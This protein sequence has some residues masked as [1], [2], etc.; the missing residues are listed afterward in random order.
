M[1]LLAWDSPQ[2]L[3][4]LL[5]HKRVNVRKVGS[6]PVVGFVDAGAAEALASARVRA[7]FTAI[8]PRRSWALSGRSILRWSLERVHE[9]VNEPVAAYP[10]GTGRSVDAVADS[11][12]LRRRHNGFGA[13]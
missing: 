5:S 1:G 6:V 4:T 12:V 9:A 8:R 13:G 2:A 3:G 10:D 11:I 7:H